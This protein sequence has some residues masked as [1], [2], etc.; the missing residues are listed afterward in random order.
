VIAIIAILIALL[1]PAVQAAREAARRMQ[2]SN[3]LK[4]VGLAIHNFHDAQ[5]G[6][7]P[8]R[9]ICLHGTWANILWPYLEQG[10]VDD[11]WGP[12]GYHYQP[13][14]NR[15]VQVAVYYCPSRRGPPQVS[16]GDRW[17][18]TGP[19]RAGALADY[20]VVVGDA[21]CPHS[22]LC[23]QLPHIPVHLDY[24]AR[25][26][27]GAFAHAG[28]Y[29]N[30][31]IPN[32]QQVCSGNVS[33]GDYDFDHNELPF[34]FTSVA[35]GLSNTLFVGEKHVP[36]EGFGNEWAGDGSIYN[37]DNLDGCARWAGPGY[38]LVRDADWNDFT[39]WYNNY[40]GSSH[41]GICQ[42][43]FGDGHVA[44]LSVQVGEP[45]LGFLATKADGEVVSSTD[46]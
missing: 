41:P 34:S 16:D 42:F 38:G 43:L 33:I 29:V 46:Y 36:P 28:P 5:Q 27:P 14:E 9:Q 3:H 8:T 11:Q 37:G 35:D 10:A 18:G 12:K 24:P 39:P 32:N 40:F 13:E 31:G 4:Q 21:R 20:A 44:A 26:V 23:A 6:L 2:C 45:V 19:P 17:S 7:P 30:D 22:S 25:E 15:T 1:L